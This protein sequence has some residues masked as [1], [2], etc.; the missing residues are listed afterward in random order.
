MQPGLGFTSHGQLSCLQMINI[1]IPQ[2]LSLQDA[3]WIPP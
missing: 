1:K 3:R 2:K